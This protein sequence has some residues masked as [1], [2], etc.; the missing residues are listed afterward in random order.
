MKSINNKLK[1][2]TSKFCLVITLILFAT[3]LIGTVHA[4]D[5]DLT[6]IVRDNWTNE[7]IKGASVKI[8]DY[9]SPYD[10][11]KQGT[12]LANGTKKFSLPD[13][14]DVYVVVSHDEYNDYYRYEWVSTYDR[15]VYIYLYRVEY[16][17]D[18]EV[19][20]WTEQSSLNPG[21][22][23]KLKVS[24]YNENETHAITLVNVTVEFPWHGY[25]EGEWIGNETIVEDLPAEIE[26]EDY[27]SYT[28]S[29]EVPSDSRGWLP[30]TTYYFGQVVFNVEAPAWKNV[31][32]VTT[33]GPGY[34]KEPELT[35]VKHQFTTTPRVPLSF[36]MSDRS[37]NATLSMIQ[38]LQII[39]IVC[40]V[41]LIAVG[42]IISGRLGKPIPPAT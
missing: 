17:G 42:L 34:K 16:T 23:G 11:L 19:E 15:T 24:I 6:V 21:A 38:I 5:P 20:A 22:K 8:Y 32:E 9:Y 31:V 30:L 12:T 27:W 26:A 10:L 40:M 29:F 2:N 28:L 39:S 37:A 1:K 3:V 7:P 33:A 41:I 18:A 35:T 13:Y 4:A 14:S 25:Y 36:P